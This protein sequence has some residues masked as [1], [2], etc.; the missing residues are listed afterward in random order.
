MWDENLFFL[1]KI[2]GLDDL[3]AIR[4]PLINIGSSYPFWPVGSTARILDMASFYL[5]SINQDGSKP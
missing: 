3:K 5:L 4:L 2:K 1:K